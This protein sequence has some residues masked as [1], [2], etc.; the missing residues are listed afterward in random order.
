M[1]VRGR[2]IW[3]VPPS[4][5]QSL[6]ER[7]QPARKGFLASLKE[8]ITIP[9][10]I[11]GDTPLVDALNLFQYRDNRYILLDTRSFERHGIKDIARRPVKLAPRPE[12]SMSAA[13]GELLKQVGA[14]FVPRDRV[15]VVI[16]EP[17]G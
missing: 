7:L 1:E 6:A 10:G 8:P 2:T 13:L 14:T 5:P 15:I 12:V 4:K 16:P 17:G 11:A 3:I 9:E